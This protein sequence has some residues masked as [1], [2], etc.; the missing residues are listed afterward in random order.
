MSQILKEV[1]L[2]V[3]NSKQGEFNYSYDESLRKNLSVSKEDLR[4]SKKYL[5]IEISENVL[6]RKF[7]YKL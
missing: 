3:K 5:E 2:T 7:Q 1:S 6:I 4:S